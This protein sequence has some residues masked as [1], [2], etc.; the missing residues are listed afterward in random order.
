MCLCIS[1]LLLKTMILQCADH[2]ECV[3]LQSIMLQVPLIH[4]SLTLAQLHRTM[5]Y[6]MI[7]FKKMCFFSA[8]VY[9]PVI[10]AG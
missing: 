4:G 1:G 2:V 6:V 7:I 3:K 10:F 9:G 5:C 8:V